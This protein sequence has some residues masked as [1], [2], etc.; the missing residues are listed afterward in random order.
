[1]FESLFLSENEKLVKKWKAEHQAIGALA[2]KIIEAYD[3]GDKEKTKKYL[4]ELDS[5]TSGHIMREDLVFYNM[6]KKKIPVDEKTMR[7]IE[8]FCN[9]FKGTK[10][11]VM[12]FI[13]K[14]ASDKVEL[15]DEFIKA[16]K[17]LVKAVVARI[18]YE[19]NNLYVDMVKKK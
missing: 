10:T 6:R 1:M 7:H 19:E 18:N 14:Y 8:E 12:N 3:A 5:L 17:G 16:F 13:A 2:G 11:T 15:D 4:K 9:S